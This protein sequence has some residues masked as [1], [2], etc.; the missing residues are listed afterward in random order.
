MIQ[1]KNRTNRKEQSF[2]FRH[3]HKDFVSTFI[4][5]SGE[6]ENQPPAVSSCS[7]QGLGSPLPAWWGGG[8]Y[9]PSFISLS[10]CFMM[11]LRRFICQRKEVFKLGGAGDLHQKV[12]ARE[13][14][15]KLVSFLN[16]RSFSSQR[17]KL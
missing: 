13:T 12:M 5:S 7:V 2:I 16:Y 11:A 17:A 3:F 14:E 9:F 8:V 10:R 6:H 4:L 1:E 15:Q